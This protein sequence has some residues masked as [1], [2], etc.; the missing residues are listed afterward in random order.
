VSG[1][2]YLSNFLGG[3]QSSNSSFISQSDIMSYR[4]TNHTKYVISHNG[5]SNGTERARGL[6]NSTTAIS[7]IYIGLQSG[8]FDVGTTFSLYGILRY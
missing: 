7:T 8:S 3:V 1:E 6:W 4:N 2:L 5:N